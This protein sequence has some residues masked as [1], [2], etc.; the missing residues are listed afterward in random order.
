MASELG[1]SKERKKQEL[2]DAALFLKSMGI[3]ELS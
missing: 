1:W 2:R 3:S